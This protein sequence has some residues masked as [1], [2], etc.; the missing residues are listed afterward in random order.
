MSKDEIRAKINEIIA[1]C[2]DG[3]ISYKIAL[4]MIAHC[5]NHDF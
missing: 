1:S 3:E 4:I 5:I 2:Y